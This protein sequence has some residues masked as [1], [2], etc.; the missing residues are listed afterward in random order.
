MSELPTLPKKSSLGRRILGLVSTAI[1]LSLVGY[2]TFVPSPYVVEN[3]GPVYNILG[4]YGGKP[5]LD[6]PS[7]KTYPVS[8]DLDLLTITIDG[9]PSRGAS[10]V[11]VGLSFLDPAKKLYLKD[12]IFP[13]GS[14]NQQVADEAEQMMVDSQMNSKAAAL[15]ELGIP[16]TTSVKVTSVTKSGAAWKILR[17]GD[18]LLR[19]DGEKATGIEQVRAA[20]AK[21][22]GK[23]PLVLDVSRNGKELTFEIV[24]KKDEGKWRL[25]IFVQSISEFP[26]D[27]NISLDNVSGPSGGQIFALAIYDK[28]T[29]GALTGGEKVAGTGTIDPD[30][31]IG[32]IG[33][34]Q[35]KMYGAV[36]AGA[37]YFLAPST[38]CDEVVGHVPD[39]LQVIKVSKLDDSIAAL[40]AI[41]SGK[42]NSLATCTVEGTK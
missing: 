14:D 21:T 11:M 32:P 8:G 31:T 29:P 22:E 20:V 28:L 7:Q 16:I 34:I 19:V 41:S 36:R 27:I 33:G 39:G 37:K 24:P 12:E 42:A 40:K 6:I 4:N 26:F 23:R 15:N 30:G 17:A 9:S 13:P 1:L 5:L 2:G 35:S 25:G 10:W 3:P 18:T 38:N